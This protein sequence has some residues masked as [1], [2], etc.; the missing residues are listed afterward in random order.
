MKEKRKTEK[1]K[2]KSRRNIE[3]MFKWGEDK[4]KMKQIE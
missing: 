2:E 4:T 3:K 1:E